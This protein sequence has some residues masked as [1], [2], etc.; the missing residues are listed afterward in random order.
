MPDLQPDHAHQERR[1]L[2]RAAVRLEVGRAVHVRLQERDEVRPR[3]AHDEVVDVEQLGNAPQRRVSVVV[4]CVGPVVEVGRVGGR[5]GDDVTVDVFAE[6][7]GFA[8][9]VQRCRRCVG[10]NSCCPDQLE[11][12]VSF[13]LDDQ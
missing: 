13:I 3:L 6:E 1:E 5:P 2:R 7:R 9:S 12:G 4:R 8:V 11:G 10:C